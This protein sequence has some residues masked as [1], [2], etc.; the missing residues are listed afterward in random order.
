MACPPCR[1]KFV[2]PKGGF[3]ELPHNF[4]MQQFMKKDADLK[5]ESKKRALPCDLCNIFGQKQQKREF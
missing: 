2:I 3:K 4:Y 1:M 5:P